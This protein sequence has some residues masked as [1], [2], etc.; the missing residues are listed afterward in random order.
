MQALREGRE[1]DP[2]VRDIK[3]EQQRR[4]FNRYIAYLWVINHQLG[5]VASITAHRVEIAESEKTRFLLL[6]E[7]ADE[8]D[9]AEG[10]PPSK[11][12]RNWRNH[13]GTMEIAVF[14]RSLALECR[15]D[16][17][18]MVTHLWQ[19]VASL[20]QVWADLSLEFAGEDVVTREYREMV[21]DVRARLRTCADAFGLKKLP[22][23]P[24]AAFVESW[25]GLVNDSFHQLSIVEPYA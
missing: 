9:A 5:A 23:E 21:T 13:K 1:V 25:T 11:A 12:I 3:D 20:E 19:E 7:A 14:L 10:K 4:A 16:G 15:D 17:A 2:A 24:E 8:V 18:A 6:N 22:S